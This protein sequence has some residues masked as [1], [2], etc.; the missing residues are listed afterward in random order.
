M[1]KKAQNY[2]DLIP[3][4]N[5]N[6]SYSVENGIVK[7]YIKNKG[8]FHYITQKL[9]KKPTVSTIELEEI[10]SCIWQSIDEKNDIFSIVF[11]SYRCCVSNRD[12]RF[13]DHSCIWIDF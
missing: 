4:H 12:S 11:C 8:F 9:C 5:K 6:I 13:N 2:L 3:V 7:L 1:N 10:G